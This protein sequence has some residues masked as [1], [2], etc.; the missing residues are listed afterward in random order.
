MKV[1]QMFRI[2][3]GPLSLSLLFCSLGP[4]LPCSQ[5]D[6][7]VLLD[8]KTD[9]VPKDVRGDAEKERA[10]FTERYSSQLGYYKKALE[11]LTGEHVCKTYIYS[12]ALAKTVT[13]DLQSFY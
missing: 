5:K 11:K 13:L 4:C 9:R 8:Y 12:F 7:W 2:S 10:F 1:T 6:K 3:S